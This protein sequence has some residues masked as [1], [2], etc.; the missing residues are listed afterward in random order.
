MNYISE[1][2][3]EGEEDQGRMARESEGI[4]RKLE[5]IR[6]AM[7]TQHESSNNNLNDYIPYGKY[8]SSKGAKVE[9]GREDNNIYSYRQS[10]EKKLERLFKEEKIGFNESMSGGQTI[11]NGSD[12]I[13][14]GNFDNYTKMNCKEEFTIEKMEY[15]IK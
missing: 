10:L 1:S 7:E 5:R 4:M 9:R 14:K 12:V 15:R 6:N 11:N 13:G 2:Q 8:T 3:G